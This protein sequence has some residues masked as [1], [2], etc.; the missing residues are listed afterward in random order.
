MGGGGGGAPKFIKA[1][2]VIK[3]LIYQRRHKI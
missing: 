3:H 1:G 2:I